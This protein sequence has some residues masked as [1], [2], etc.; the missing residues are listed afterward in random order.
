MTFVA[1]KRYCS[2]S[3]LMEWGCKMSAP[4]ACEQVLLF[5]RVKRVSRERASSEAARGLGPSL[6]R[7]REA[8]FA[9][10]NRRACSQASTPSASG[11]SVKW[12]LLSCR[13]SIVQSLFNLLNNFIW[14]LHPCATLRNNP[15]NVNGSLYR[16]L[17]SSWITQFKIVRLHL[18]NIPI[19]K[20]KKVVVRATQFLITTCDSQPNNSHSN[21]THC[22]MCYNTGTQRYFHP[23]CFPLLDDC[24]LWT[25]V[26][27]KNFKGKK[28]SL[29]EMRAA[30]NP[31]KSLERFLIRKVHPFKKIVRLYLLN[32]HT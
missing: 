12:W 7:S 27:L 28:G 22:W 1:Q 29:G 3:L 15:S 31:L 13:V 20:Q 26:F 5:E 30:E 16:F 18:I 32:A 10:P 6:A 11:L 19:T 24:A 17:Y 14:W 8:R 23:W 9:C 2:S 25:I 21:H 4:L